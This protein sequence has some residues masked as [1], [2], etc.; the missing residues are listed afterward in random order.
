MT[1]LRLE[2]FEDGTDIVLEGG[3][4]ALSNGIAEA[5]LVSLFSDGTASEDV[6]EL[7]GLTDR[8]GWWGADPGDDYGSLLWLLERSKLDDKL[9]ARVRDTCT[10]AL[11]WI[12]DLGFAERVSVEAAVDP[13]SSRLD[14]A[15]TLE[16][17]TARQWDHYWR[18]L[19]TGAVTTSNLDGVRLRLLIR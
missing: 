18:G 15:V 16:R 8:R 17:G 7:E 19:E 11:R 2:V 12:T 10:A 5:V 13:A 14:L 6:L 1:D 4:L 9:P 3:D